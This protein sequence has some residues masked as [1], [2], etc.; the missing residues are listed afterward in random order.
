MRSD[1]PDPPDQEQSR[2]EPEREGSDD[3]GDEAIIA[4][5]RVVQ[6]LKL[7]EMMTKALE[8]LRAKPK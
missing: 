8:Q 7:R 3:P 1:E 6:R 4:F 2:Q 5:A